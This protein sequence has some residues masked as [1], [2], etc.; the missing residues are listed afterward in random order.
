[1]KLHTSP[2]VPAGES[3]FCWHDPCLFCCRTGNREG[4]LSSLLVAPWRKAECVTHANCVS[5]CTSILHN[6]S[7]TPPGVLLNP[8]RH[9]L[10]TTIVVAA[11]LVPFACR[12][13]SNETEPPVP[14]LDDGAPMFFEGYSYSYFVTRDLDQNHFYQQMITVTYK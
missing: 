13:C 8:V 2:C 7:Q 1:M 10:Q 9:D 14:M 4:I 5:S 11:K 6:P 12:W 3:L